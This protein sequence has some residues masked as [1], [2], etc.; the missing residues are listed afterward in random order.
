MYNGGAKISNYVVNRRNSNSS[1]R[2][3]H[4]TIGSNTPVTG[5]V[6]KCYTDISK[7]STELEFPYRKDYMGDSL[8]KINLEKIFAIE[9]VIKKEKWT[10]PEG[11]IINKI[12]VFNDLF[13]NLDIVVTSVSNHW[14][15]DQ[16]IDYYSEKARIKTPGYGEKYSPYDYWTTQSLHNRWLSK[17]Q[18]SYTLEEIRELIYKNI[19]EARPAYSLI[20]KSLY[21]CLMEFNNKDEYKILDIAAYGERAIAASSL[22]NVS[23][24]DGVD[25]NYDLIYGHDLLAMDLELLNP[26]CHIK[27][28][29]V[30]LED[31]KS[32]RKYDIITYS[33]PPYN[34]EPYGSNQ[35]TQT[36]IKYPTFDEYFCC[37]LTELIYKARM[38]SNK[39]A[40]FSFTAL[41]RN[42]KKYPPKIKDPNQIS[43][44]LELVY[45]EALL[46][47]I[48]C[49][50]FQYKG[51]IGLAAGGKQAGVPW[52][53]FKYDETFDIIYM[54]LF[55]K[56]Y[57]NLFNT[58]FPRIVSNYHSIVNN[59][60]PFMEKYT[61]IIKTPNYYISS[62]LPKKTTVILELIRLQI[63]QYIIE[64][65]SKITG[66]RIEKI[67]VLL[68]R[69]LMMKSID[70]T[71]QMPWNSC[72]YLDPI[73]PTKKTHVL[74]NDPIS[75]QII[76][77]LIEQKVNKDLAYKVM[78]TNKYWF[79]SYECT[80]L[81]DL[82]HTIAHFIHT[83]PLS[84]ASVDIQT[85][86][87]FTIIYGN[88]YIVNLL[89][90]IPKS[91]NP[92]GI[93]NELWKGKPDIDLLPYL[94]YETLGAQGH[95]YTR[96][97]EKTAIIEQIFTMP[98]I[99]IYAS[100]YNN[101]SKQYC[102]IYPDV[103]DNSIG[104]AFCLRMIEG[105][106]LANPV[107]VPIFLE[108]ALSI[109]IEDL[110]RAKRSNKVLLISMGFTVW[111]DTEDYFIKEFGDKISY[112][113]LF[114]KSKNRGLN[115][116]AE[117]EFILAT[118]ILDKKK[119]PS[120]LLDKVGNR[121]NTISVGVILGSQ[122][123]IIKGD[124]ISKLVE[125]KKYIQY[126]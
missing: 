125:D 13:Y 90:K 103:E 33:P 43:E 9:T 8:V 24:Y 2:N 50:G 96:P 94:R 111:T 121:D 87:G 48:S 20:S 78:Y 112:I 68:G 76:V 19:Q 67:R 60:H 107:D 44:N 92:C 100:I 69:Y 101:Q 14:E 120:V 124:I 45:I 64:I 123:G 95:Q 80:G 74:I 83:L 4:K 97:L 15:Y 56:H 25:P 82:Y 88:N 113:Q 29:H 27:F 106:Y 3:S 1:I 18:I 86:E 79:G 34:T 62:F 72:L 47:L 75:D 39:G 114:K 115:I 55:E 57:P 126:N 35:D 70:A 102:S 46:L 31:F 65:I 54:H 53:T 38:F 116:L 30:G 32:S 98:V 77:Y 122:K 6:E 10:I 22:E 91:Y 105:G 7:L 85:K 81:N 118:Y 108:R 11:K 37:F 58:I 66:I 93:T 104:S 52:W 5:K 71:F 41:D 63:Q 16:I 21:A 109:I 119:Y 84:Q 17:E 40:V 23:I 26:N 12:V 99:D 59:L 36:Y 110:H 51:A 73:F 28:I 89:K 61:A 42:P 117:S 49:F